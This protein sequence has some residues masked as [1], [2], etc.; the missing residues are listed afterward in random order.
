MGELIDLAR[1]GKRARTNVLRNLPPGRPKNAELRTREYLLPDEVKSMVAHAGTLGRHR[2]RDRTI[3]LTMYR[4]G[5]RV[6]ELI[7]LK[8]EQV[9]F[10]QAEMHIRRLKN[11]T[12]SVQPIKGDELRLLRKVRREYDSKFVF[13]SERGL[14]LS[15]SAVA[16]IM[17]RA[18][19]Y[20]EIEL[21]V[22]PHMLRHACGYYLANKNIDT[23][24]I[25]AYLGH[26]SIQHT[27]RY[28]ELAP[29]RFSDLW[30]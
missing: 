20:A 7:D 29:G 2:T 12:P 21:K 24:T 13:V 9:D 15:R 14:P 3:I 16:A 6:S 26:R 25:Q 19:E 28:T 30:D 10:R 8:W 17:K 22:H 18:G 23:R 27:V 5:L 1:H 11:G 4:H